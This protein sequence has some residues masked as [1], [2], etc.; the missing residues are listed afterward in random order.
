MVKIEPLSR[1]IVV[2]MDLLL[3]ADPSQ[4]RVFAY[5]QSG[6]CYVAIHEQDIIGVYVLSPTSKDIVEIMNI[7]VKEAWQGRG[8][9]KQLVNHAI[10]EV[11]KTGAQ[12]IEIGTGNSSIA[13]LAIYQKCGF[14]MTSIERD[15]FLKHYDEPIYENGIRCLDMIRLSLSL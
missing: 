5:V 3:L 2:P 1:H 6:S 9:G 13:Q 15:F 7:A 11:K 8:I 4:E 10:S 14:R 12:S